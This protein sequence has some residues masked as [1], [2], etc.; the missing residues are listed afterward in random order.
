MQGVLGKLLDSVQQANLAVGWLTLFRLVT[1]VACFA[2]GQRKVHKQELQKIGVAFR[3]LARS[4]V[5]PPAVTDWTQPWH[6]I[7]H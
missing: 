3:R 6:D 1:P 5:G 2:A 4:I 7:L